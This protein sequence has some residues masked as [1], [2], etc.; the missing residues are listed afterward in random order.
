[1]NDYLYK[2]LNFSYL[3]LLIILNTFY[4]KSLIFD[5]L[6]ILKINKEKYYFLTNNINLLMNISYFYFIFISLFFKNENIL[7]L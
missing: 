4:N 1:M 5:I 7:Y 3:I 6:F 2:N